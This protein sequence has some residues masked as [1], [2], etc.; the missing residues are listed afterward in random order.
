LY[1]KHD[2]GAVFGEGRAANRVSW[3][4]RRGEGHREIISYL[5]EQLQ[6]WDHTVTALRGQGTNNP[7][8]CRL[9]LPTPAAMK[10]APVGRAT[11]M[12]ANDLA[13]VTIATRDLA[14]LLTRGR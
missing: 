5:Y 14:G 4:G 3:Y 9:N 11:E 13:T 10:T 12:H 8:F 2:I 7:K 1:A 6:F